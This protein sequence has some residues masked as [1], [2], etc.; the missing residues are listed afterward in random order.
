VSRDQVHRILLFVNT[1]IGHSVERVHAL[2]A[3]YD[4]IHVQAALDLVEVW[5]ALNAGD[6]ERAAPAHQPLPAHDR[7]R[8]QL[9][10]A[11]RRTALPS[12]EAERRDAS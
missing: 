11:T 1:A 7:L 5:Q 6:G 9:V 10:P 4:D 3:L 8:A 2:A 12:R